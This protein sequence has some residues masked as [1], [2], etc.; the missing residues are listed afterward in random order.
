MFPFSR[1]GLSW[2]RPFARLANLSRFV[3]YDVDLCLGTSLHAT[4]LRL[5]EVSLEK[6]PRQY[7]VHNRRAEATGIRLEQRHVLHQIERSCVSGWL[8]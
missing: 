8:S 3:F 1:R 5:E 7:G 4:G 2:L 6:H